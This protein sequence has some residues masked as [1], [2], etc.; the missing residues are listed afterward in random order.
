[1]SPRFLSIALD[2]S[3]VK[4]GYDFSLPRLSARFDLRERVAQEIYRDLLREHLVPE[5]KIRRLR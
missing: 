3:N 4:G 2:S 5:Y 1:M